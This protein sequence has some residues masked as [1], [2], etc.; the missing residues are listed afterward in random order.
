MSLETINI[1]KVFFPAVLA[2]VIGIIITPLFTHFFYH[3]KMWKK[4]SRSKDNSEGMAV[5]FHKIHNEDDELNTPRLGGMIIWVSA[6][7][8][9]ALVYIAS[10]SFPTEQTIKMNFFSRNQTF[11]PLV[12]LV[13]AS[14]IGLSDDLLQIFGKGEYAKDKTTY[15]FIK[16]G[17][18]L[19]IGLFIGWW[20]YSKLGMS[21]V[22]IPFGGTLHLGIL[23]IPF[24]IVIMLAVFS[25][26]VIDGIDGLAGGVMGAIFIGYAAIAFGKDMF[27]LAA[28]S[29]MVGGGTLAFLWFNIPPARF[30]LGETG[31]LGLT[32]TL[33]TIAFLTDTVFLLPI[34]ALPLAATTFSDIVQI[35][36]RNLFGKRVF[37]LAPLHHHFEAIGWPKYK[38][39]MR[40]WIVG[41]VA[42]IVGV[43]VALL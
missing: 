7:I 19:A 4:S 33:A 43:S 37:R 9:I 35:A 18:L 25:G 38:V 42:P 13:L 28:F 3:Y 22:H 36:S 15:R 21:D 26:S 41:L 10:K 40:Y 39:T 12:T 8:T 14:L 29:A 11:I 30:Y 23:F 20:F 6:L 17:A 2:F 5:D 34:I 24:F 27:D 1:I 32:V 31:I 16:I